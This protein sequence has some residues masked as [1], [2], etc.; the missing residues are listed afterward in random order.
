MAARI[1]HVGV[2]CG[3]QHRGIDMDAAEL[4]VGGMLVADKRLQ[5]LG[6]AAQE[7]ERRVVRRAPLGI[8][9]AAVDIDQAA[10][11]LDVDYVD[12]VRTEQ[13]KV[14]LEDRVPLPELEV[15]NDGEA[16][17]QM[18]AQVGN[19]LPLRL[20]DRLADGDHLRHQAAPRSSIQRSRRDRASRS[21]M[22]ASWRA[23]RTANARRPSSSICLS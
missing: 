6:V 15:V 1:L 22:T 14:D 18:V 21:L 16:V 17:R 3:H 13:C 10:R 5:R 12:A 23:V 20:V 4:P 7:R 8:P 2:G 11:A 19:R 9:L